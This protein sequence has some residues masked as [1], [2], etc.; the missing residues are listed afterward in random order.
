MDVS[1]FI[2]VLV[3]LFPFK[4]EIREIIKEFYDKRFKG[5]EEQRSAVSP[6]EA[7]HL[8]TFYL[9]LL[10]YK[11]RDKVIQKAIE[12]NKKYYNIEPRPEQM[13]YLSS[14]PPVIY[15][16][17]MYDDHEYFLMEK[18]GTQ[19]D[20]LKEI[21]EVHEYLIEALKKKEK[22][23]QVLI[24]VIE[25]YNNYRYWYAVLS[26]RAYRVYLPDYEKMHGISI[27][28]DT[29]NIGVAHMQLIQGFKQNSKYYH[30]NV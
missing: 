12:L 23:G 16:R 15:T 9:N 7:S 3:D 10:D 28:R 11:H 14:L 6:T 13:E 27:E 21:K 5:S 26:S 25:N 24:P 4:L 8:F 20:I 19:I 29:P 18:T 30:I 1:C 2:Y 17:E 22:Y